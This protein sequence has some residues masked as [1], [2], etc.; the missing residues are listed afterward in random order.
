MKRLLPSFNLWWLFLWLITAIPSLLTIA[1]FGGRYWWGFELATHFRM[2][3]LVILTIVAFIFLKQKKITVA[4]LAGSL[5][6]ANLFIVFPIAPLVHANSDNSRSDRVVLRALLA[7]VDHNNVT[8][9]QFHNLVETTNP[10]ILV[11]VEINE[12][13]METLRKWASRYPFQKS[14][15]HKQYGLGVLSRIPFKNADIR[16]LA[17]DRLPSV[18]IQFQ[19]ENQ[20]FV[21]VGAHPHSPVSPIELEWRNQYL[22]EL[23]HLI[24]SKNTPIVLL[25]D[26]NTSPWSPYFKDFI[27]STRLRDTRPGYGVGVTWPSKAWPLWIPIDHCLVSSGVSIHN[28]QVGPDFGSDHYPL[29]VEFSIHNP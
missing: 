25:G 6:M 24:A 7:N 23:A 8:Y 14:L 4:I 21:L 17:P 15:P 18:L 5:A 29:L 13:W 26:L 20:D 10:D 16:I 3:Y 11:L 22:K 12:E 19:L 2:Q 9:H 28:R 1:A 27:T